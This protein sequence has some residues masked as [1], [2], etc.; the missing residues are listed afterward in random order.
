[1]THSLNIH[2]S[3]NVLKGPIGHKPTYSA[4]FVTSIGAHN[5]RKIRTLVAHSAHPESLTERY[6]R[7]WITSFGLDVTRIRS[8]AVSFSTES[9]TGDE[10]S[11]PTLIPTPTTTTVA[12]TPASALPGLA[13]SNLQQHANFVFLPPPLANPS[14]FNAGNTV[15]TLI[16]NPATVLPTPITLVGSSPLPALAGGS[17]AA[18]LTATTVPL[19]TSVIA[20]N[21]IGANASASSASENVESSSACS[22]YDA[23]WMRLVQRMNGWGFVPAGEAEV[24]RWVVRKNTDLRAGKRWLIYVSPSTRQQ[25]VLQY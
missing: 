19:A 4:S 12:I 2:H 3:P 15:T 10:D 17:I 23:V 22:Q 5:A 20:S 16:L 9:T 6:L 1:M 18:T 14:S 21:F 24:D 11:N 7:N 25:R 8:L 13:G